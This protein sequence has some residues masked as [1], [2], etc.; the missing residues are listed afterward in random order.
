M[1][2]ASCAHKG[3]IASGACTQSE[4]FMWCEAHGGGHHEGGCMYDQQ[5][6]SLWDQRLKQFLL[7]N[8]VAVVLL[9]PIEEDTW[10]NYAAVG[11]LFRLNSLFLCVRGPDISFL[12]PEPLISVVSTRFLPLQPR[13]LR[14]FPRIPSRT[15]P[16]SPFFNVESTPFLRDPNG[17]GRVSAAHHRGHGLAGV[18]GHQESLRQHGRRCRQGLYR[19]DV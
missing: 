10:D 1:A 19:R 17:S 5:A 13:P 18:G 8:G 7:A 12:W 3:P 15:V 2:C 6:G 14:N 16:L 4:A 9:N 11:D